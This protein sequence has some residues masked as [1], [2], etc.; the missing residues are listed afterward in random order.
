MPPDRHAAEDPGPLHRALG[1][2]HADLEH[3][4]VGLGLLEGGEAADDRARRC[5]PGRS[6]PRRRTSAAR[7]RRSS[8]APAR[9]FTL[10]DAGPDVGEAPGLVL[11]AP[12]GVADHQ[13]VEAGA[14]HHRE[15][16]AVDH[17]EVERPAVAVEAD[18]DGL[19]DRGRDARGWWPAGWRCRRGG[20]PRRPAR[21]RGRRGSA[22]PCRRRP[23]RRRG[24]RPRRPPPSPR[25]APSCSSGPRTRAARRPRGRGRERSSSR[26]PPSD[27]LAW[28]TDGDGGHRRRPAVGV[29][30]SAR[31]RDEPRRHG[32]PRRR[33]P[34]ARAPE[35]R[36][37]ADHSR[38]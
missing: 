14:G 6:S 20:S 9:A 25:P 33:R 35:Q 28:A 11:Q 30:S 4:V 15:V 29:R 19:L 3:A 22:A 23:T 24:R 21:R 31:A 37:P 12:V 27:F 16:L 1:L 5:R 8:W 17:A 10:R 7:R 32:W 34:R 26:P 36:G 38:W 18:L 2:D 13:G